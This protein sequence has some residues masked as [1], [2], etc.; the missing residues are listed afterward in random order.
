MDVILLVIAVLAVVSSVDLEEPMK[1]RR[2]L[3]KT[4]DEQYANKVCDSLFAHGVSY[5]MFRKNGQFR[6]YLRSE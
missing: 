2:L 6:I 3:I 4:S 5:S 1:R